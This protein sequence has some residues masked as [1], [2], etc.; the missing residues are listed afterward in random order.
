[1]KH[2][3]RGPGDFQAANFSNV[4]KKKKITIPLQLPKL[5][6]I[7]WQ[8][9]A[10]DCSL[11]PGEVLPHFSFYKSLSPSIRWMKWSF[12][13]PQQYSLQTEAGRASTFIFWPFHFQPLLALVNI[14]KIT[15]CWKGKDR[16]EFKKI[17]NRNLK[18]FQSLLNAFTSGSSPRWNKQLSCLLICILCLSTFFLFIHKANIFVIIQ[19]QT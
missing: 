6:M 2:T 13:S 11:S 19:I 9:L 15:L 4:K 5:G 17:Y 18:K 3:H 14:R 1:M 16:R 12:W 10:T 7:Q 8:Q